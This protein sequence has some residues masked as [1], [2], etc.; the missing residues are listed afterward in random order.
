VASTL[1]TLER[2]EQAVGA[3]NQLNA[4]RFSEVDRRLVEIANG[5]KTINGTVRE[6]CTAIELLRQAGNTRQKSIDALEKATEGLPIIAAE[7]T[8][9]GVNWER[10]WTIVVGPILAAILTLV[11]VQARVIR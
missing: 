8:R 7:Q 6:N 4:S 11:L 10:V 2:I 1:Q 5:L 9:Q 3:G